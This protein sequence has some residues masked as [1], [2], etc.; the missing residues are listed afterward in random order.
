MLRS[1]CACAG[2]AGTW[3]FSQLEV[4]QHLKV[5]R[6]VLSHIE[7]D[8]YGLGTPEL[9][10]L[11]GLYRYPVSYFA[12]GFDPAESLGE[13]LEPLLQ[14]TAGLSRRGREEARRFTE[15]LRPRKEDDESPQD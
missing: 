14:T 10:W 6:P 5:S 2:C 15:N 9:K 4:V 8:R 11:A 12:G 1:A 13:V 7:N 3:G